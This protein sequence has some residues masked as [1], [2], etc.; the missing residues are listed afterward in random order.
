[1]DAWKRDDLVYVETEVAET[2]LNSGYHADKALYP[3]G[4]HSWSNGDLMLSRYD[5][6][7]RILP[8]EEV[9]DAWAERLNGEGVNFDRVPKALRPLLI[10]RGVEILPPT[11]GMGKD[12]KTAFEEW[13]KENKTSASERSG[14]V[15][16]NSS[17]DGLLNES[18][19]HLS[20]NALASQEDVAKLKK[21]S[22]NI[23][24][25]TK[26]YKCRWS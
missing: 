6:P 13:K 18:S 1:M 9:A 23:I 7:V 26:S 24:F 16:G 8:W 17:S 2:D 10:E 5:K 19:E 20:H 22:N 11:K 3:V 4:V 14:A 12:C 15:P 21:Y 25:C